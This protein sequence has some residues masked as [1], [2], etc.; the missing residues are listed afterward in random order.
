[1]KKK[2][3]FNR[4]Q[5]SREF[6]GKLEQISKELKE[7]N[8]SASSEQLIN[9]TKRLHRY[10]RYADLNKSPENKIIICCN[11][12]NSKDGICVA[13]KTGGRVHILEYM[14]IKCHE[15]NPSYDN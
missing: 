14:I 6:F 8:E 13:D 10:C 3:Q 4:E 1:M 15:R 2:K 11:Y 9:L 12:K 5:N 7:L